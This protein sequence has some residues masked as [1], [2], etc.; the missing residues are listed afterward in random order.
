MMR[1]WPDIIVITLQHATGAMFCVPSLLGL[2]DASWASSLACL[3]C[4]S[5]AGW[6][7]EHT[8]EME[9]GKKKYPNLLVFIYL[10]HPNVNLRNSNGALLS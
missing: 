10:L 2:E 8:A 9:N 5:E 4:L 6:E 7:V 1:D 3:G